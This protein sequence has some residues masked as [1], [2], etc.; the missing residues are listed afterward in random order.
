[1]KKFIIYGASEFA[2]IMRYYLEKD[3]NAEVVA[4]TADRKYIT[5]TFHEGLPV[6]PFEEVQDLYEPSTHSM[7]IAIIGKK[8]FN[9]RRDVYKAIKVKGYDLPNIIHTTASV[10]CKDI[11]DA[12]II[13]D[14][15]VLGP[16]SRIGSGN[17][18][19]PC[20]SI[21]HSNIVGDFNQFA[22]CSS[23]VGMLTI[24]SHNF[25]G[26]NCTVKAPVGDY[27]FIGAAAYIRKPTKDYAVYS[28]AKTVQ[29]NGMNSIDI[30]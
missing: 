2:E 26:N 7:V 10:N 20:V 30:Y 14:N 21:A 16:N 22:G 11:G 17:I 23:T 27:V 18:V 1:M 5:E 19:W 29:I 8:M 12:N 3:N 4:F 25:V 28:P 15:S 13:M 9:Q 24:G 6:V